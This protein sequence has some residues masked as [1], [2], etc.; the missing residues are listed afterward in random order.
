MR[1]CDLEHC[2]ICVTCCAQL[3]DTFD[4]LSVRDSAFDADMLR[5]AMTLTFDRWP[6]KFVEYEASR[7]ES[8]YE[9]L[10]K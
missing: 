3:W 1:D 6:W 2:V 9:N 7:D 8:L 10:A 5:P 4:N